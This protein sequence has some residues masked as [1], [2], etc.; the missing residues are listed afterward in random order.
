MCAYIVSQFHLFNGAIDR[1]RDEDGSSGNETLRKV[2]FRRSDTLDNTLRGVN[3]EVRELCSL[4]LQF[5]RMLNDV[6]LEL[7]L[8]LRLLSNSAFMVMMFYNSVTS[9]FV[10]SFNELM[11]SLR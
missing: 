7:K 6:G 10:N 4:V 9:S 1:S 3:V 11:F 8:S 2:V 5:L